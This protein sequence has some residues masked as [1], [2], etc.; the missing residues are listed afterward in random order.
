MYFD[1]ILCQNADWIN[2]LLGAGHWLALGH[3]GEFPDQV[4]NNQF[5]RNVSAAWT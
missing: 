1:G 4:N 2:R 5:L 3:K